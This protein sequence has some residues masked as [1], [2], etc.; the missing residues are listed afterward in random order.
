[1]VIVGLFGANALG[2]LSGSLSLE[3]DRWHWIFIINIISAILCLILGSI[4]L[5]KEEYQHSEPIHISR[6]MIISLV[7]STIALT[8]PMGM[9]T[10]KGYGSL[11]SAYPN[12]SNFIH[13]KFCSL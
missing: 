9:L 2:G 5:T 13:C 10:Q 8:L 11:W 7:L 1:M 4:F 12:Y 6:P 3:L